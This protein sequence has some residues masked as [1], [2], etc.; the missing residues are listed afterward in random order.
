MLGN[1]A[2]YALLQSYQRSREDLELS[3]ISSYTILGNSSH[4]KVGRQKYTTKGG[5][6]YFGSR[7]IRRYLVPNLVRFL[8]ASICNCA[9]V[10]G[11]SQ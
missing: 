11:H 7:D 4:C 8:C 10:N 9:R 6:K 1:G 3:Q 5:T 2:Q